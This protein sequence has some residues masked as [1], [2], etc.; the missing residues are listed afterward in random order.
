MALSNTR[1]ERSVSGVTQSKTENTAWIYP[2]QEQRTSSSVAQCTTENTEWLYQ[3]QKQ[4]SMSG[5]T[6]YNNRDQ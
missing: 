3:I 1:T 6:P 4:R 5:V 2:I